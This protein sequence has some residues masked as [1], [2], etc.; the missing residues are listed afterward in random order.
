MGGDLNLKKSWH[1]ALMTNQRRVYNEELK[2]LEERK[3]TDQVLKERAEERAI[4]ELER[5][6]EAAGG[7]KRVD[8]VDWMYNGPGAGG[9]GVG[10]VTEEMEGYLLGKRRLD[11]LVKSGNDAIKN[12]APEVGAIAEGKGG[13]ARDIASKIA[14]DPMLA[15]KKQEQAAYEAMMADPV[16]RKMLMKA[17]GKE[18]EDE[19]SKSKERRHKHRSHRH[20]H[21]DEDDDSH[22]RKRR[23]HSDEYEDERRSHRHRSHRHRRDDSRSKSRSRSPYSRKRD[24]RDRHERRSKSHRGRDYSAS[25]SRSPARRRNDED[26]KDRR[27]SYPSPRRS[28]SRSD[29]RS[30]SRSPYQRY[31]RE[32][33]PR[34]VERRRPSPSYS[35]QR[36]DKP[37]R[38]PPEDQSKDE[39]DEEAERARK[40][41][42]MQS[43]ATELESERKTRL[44]E[45]EQKEARQREED[46]RKRSERGKFISNVRRD[47]ENVDLGRRLGGG[48]RSNGDD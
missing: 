44:T 29:S 15:I 2:A 22:R 6:Q 47:A 13:S 40:L 20:R 36:N 16:R 27:R 14:S 3:K 8:R 28:G 43:N 39:A 41:A 31:D 34:R 11:G 32:E 48:G 42:A 38:S 10:G 23:R 5:L 35:R 25:R 21:R 26:R 17:A 45:L 4:Q 12:D 30:R 33:R 19:G 37:Y 18:D 1:P 46:D 24:D 7:K 9:P